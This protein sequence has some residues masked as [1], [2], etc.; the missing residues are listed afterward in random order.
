MIDPDGLDVNGV[1][2]TVVGVIAG[3]LVTGVLIG[4]A[5]SR[6]TE[7]R[8]PIAILFGIVAATAFAVAAVVVTRTLS[9]EVTAWDLCWVIGLTGATGWLWR[10]STPRRRTAS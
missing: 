9:G 10:L 6:V 7:R 2:Y 1:V 8:A 3:V 5:A 4:L